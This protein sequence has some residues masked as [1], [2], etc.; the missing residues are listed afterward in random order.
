MFSYIVLCAAALMAG[1]GLLRLT[2]VVSDNSGTLFLAPVVTMTMWTI[3]LGWAV[4]LHLP[5]AWVVP[6][7]W[8]LTALLS[9]FGSQS[10]TQEMRHF[11][12]L[13]QLTGLLPIIL[14]APAFWH[15]LADYTGSWFWDKWYYVATGWLTVFPNTALS[16]DV[17][18]LVEYASNF[19]QCR[20]AAANLLAFISPMTGRP[21]DTVSAIHPFLA[22]GLFCY[23]SSMAFFLTRCGFL[24]RRAL[25]GIWSLVALACLGLSGWTLSVVLTNNFDNLLAISILPA[26]AGLVWYI[27][28]DTLPPQDAKSQP[29]IFEMFIPTGML[30]AGLLF[31]YPE[32][33]PAILGCAAFFILGRIITDRHHRIA[34]ITFGPA[35]V[36]LG[37]VLATPWL[38]VMIGFFQGQLHLG[39]DASTLRPGEGFFKGLITAPFVPSASFGLWMPYE[40]CVRE[41]IRWWFGI[42]NAVALPGIVLIVLGA[43]RSL[44]I[45]AWPVFATAVACSLAA[46]VM[47]IGFSYDY[48]MFKF[49]LVGW[50][51]FVILMV[52]GGYTVVDWFTRRQHQRLGASLIGLFL[53]AFLGM[54]LFH[55][56]SFNATVYPKT[57]VA[58]Q[59]LEKITQNIPKGGVG[60][61]IIDESR[62]APAIWGLRNTPVAFFSSHHE[63]FTNPKLMR[64]QADRLGSEI[65]YMLT[66]RPNAFPPNTLVRQTGPFSLYRVE[67]P[68][69][70][71]SAIAFPE[72]IDYLE[73]DGTFWLGPGTTRLS[74]QS[75]TQTLVR[76]LLV[77]RPGPSL[78]PGE[79]VRLHISTDTGYNNTLE[80]SA[81]GII[82]TVI[83]VRKG[84]T[85]LNLLPTNIP[86]PAGKA[87]FDSRT[88]I[89]K[90]EMLILVPDGQRA[91]YLVDVTGPLGID[92]INGSVWRW[93]NEKP[94]VLTVFSTV[95][96]IVHMTARLMPGPSLPGVAARFVS[97]ETSAGYAERRTLDTDDP[98]DLRIPVP[99]GMTRIGLRDLDTPTTSVPGDAR[100]LLLAIG[101][102]D[103]TFNKK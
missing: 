60:A 53:L 54:T 80:V 41:H 63:Y 62:V 28:N 83:P 76:L 34:A 51:A 100:T 9:L 11:P 2:G 29:G 70:Y 81:Y 72:H 98:L 85:E 22:L 79:P 50:F 74:V 7:V 64:P 73:P 16:P 19:S 24:Q 18:P 103:V 13:I 1:R 89:A 99:A 38:P 77:A 58:A 45:G 87:P 30:V 93:L 95:P 59:A 37:L 88:M 82:E 94:L 67:S 86:D 8:G 52:L 49:L 55:V 31:I 14:L 68:K 32:L 21:W 35:A 4:L 17:S 61:A 15:G 91:S 3:L 6:F 65:L 43:R 90:V 47:G 56:A 69:T 42:Y 33:A 48:G 20:F 23:A 84:M 78:P 101:N 5:L 44:R 75:D 39:F 27:P 92:T 71:V 36:V 57:T 46:A 12:G 96:T 10:A 97:I 40:C 102:L 66:D 26:L 25:P